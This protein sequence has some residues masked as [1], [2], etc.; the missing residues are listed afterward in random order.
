MGGADPADRDQAD[1]SMDPDR[2]KRSWDL[3]ARRGGD[4]VA[5]RFYSYLFLAHPQTRD[6]FAL[7]MAGPA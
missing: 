4:Q 6:L 1:V 5:L 7:S 3:V 2:L